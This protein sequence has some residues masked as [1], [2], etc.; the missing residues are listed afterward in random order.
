MAASAECPDSHKRQP[1]TSDQR[2]QK[3]KNT[4]RAFS[5]AHHSLTL[6]RRSSVADVTVPTVFPELR[7]RFLA[8][9]ATSGSISKRLNRAV[10]S[11]EPLPRSLAPS[12]PP[13]CAVPFP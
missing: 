7:A 8:D 13:P 1:N 10:Y 9:A 2:L 5:P 3:Q 12:L 4:Q 11:R 6:T